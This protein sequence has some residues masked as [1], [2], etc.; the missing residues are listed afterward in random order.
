MVA[1]PFGFF[2][3]HSLHLPPEVSD[4]RRGNVNSVEQ[5]GSASQS[6]EEQASSSLVDPEG[7][8]LEDTRDDI[9]C[10]SEEGSDEGSFTSHG[11]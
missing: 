6:D 3:H 10:L 1:I 7:D 4:Q 9:D 11:P 2:W 8:P 5:Q